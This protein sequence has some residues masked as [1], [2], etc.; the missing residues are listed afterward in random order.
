[1]TG[2]EIILALGVVANLAGTSAYLR[3]TFRGETK[4][5][6]VTFFLWA[7]APAIGTAAALAQGV[8]GATLPIFMNALGCAL[9]FLASFYNPRAYWRLG[10]FDWGCFALSI[11][12]IVLWQATRNPDVGIFFAI[13]SDGLAA[14]PTLK[15]CWTDPHTETAWSYACGMFSSM[16]GLV[17]AKGVV[18]SEIAF[19][20]YSVT[21]CFLL[22]TT[23]GVSRMIRRRKRAAC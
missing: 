17:V 13:L 20:L 6:R 21:A 5:N 14:L 8:R 12:A 19:P 3:D 18:F 15:K 7:L 9:I 2:H 11:A 1:M 16:T 22:F 10:L 4:P 23:I